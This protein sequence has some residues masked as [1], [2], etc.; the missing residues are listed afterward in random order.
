MVLGTDARGTCRT[1]GKVTIDLVEHDERGD[2]VVVLRGVSTARTVGNNGPA[3]IH[4]LAV[5]NFTAKK[6]VIF[7]AER[8]FRAG[9]AVVEASTNLNIDGIDSTLPGLRGRLV[10]SVASRRAAATHSQA[11]D[12]TNRSTAAQIAREFDRHVEENVRELNSRPL[13]RS[14]ASGVA[15][16]AASTSIMPCRIRTTKSYLEICWGGNFSGSETLPV[17]SLRPSK[18]EFWLHQSLAGDEAGNAL[19]AWS[20]LRDVGRRWLNPQAPIAPVFESE[21]RLALPRVAVTPVEG[22][23]VVQLSP[24]GAGDSG[25]QQTAAAQFKSLFALLQAGN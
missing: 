14:L 18:C 5:T 4:S 23:M 16:D 25:G 17:A 15:D 21:P 22:W 20:N 7:D 24:E 12:I 6:R 11:R 2:F 19:T 8:G 3:I 1:V 9:P 10:R 13:A